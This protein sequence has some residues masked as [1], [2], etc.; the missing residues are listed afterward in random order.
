MLTIQLSSNPDAGEVKR[1]IEIIGYVAGHSVMAAVAASITATP[2]A[3]PAA[4]VPPPPPSSDTAAAA[5]APQAVVPPPPPAA[6]VLD[7]RGFPWNADIHSSSKDT[8]KDGSWKKK[9]GVQDA[10]VTA[11][12]AQL[13][14][15]YPA[16]A[17]AVPPV[18]VPPVPVA[19]PPVP[20]PPVPQPA[21]AGSLDFIGLMHKISGYC[22]TG[23]LTQQD[24][25]AECQKLGVAAVPLMAQQ[26]ALI[27]HLGAALDAL[28]MSRP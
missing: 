23:K 12:E 15:H 5:F 26:P 18:P 2:L 20:V 22:G 24:V 17:A 25:A 10:V 3:A 9:R 8:N 4:V 11:T 21:A 1:A 19:V 27:P 28:A 13:R 14:Q 6:A 16:P 7:S